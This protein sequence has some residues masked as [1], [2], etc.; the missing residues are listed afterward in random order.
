M[1]E[2]QW[3][4]ELYCVSPV[5]IPVWVCCRIEVSILGVSSS[6]VHGGG[7][8]FWPE[9]VSFRWVDCVCVCVVR[10]ESRVGVRRKEDC[11]RVD[12]V[13]RSGPAERLCST[14]VVEVGRSL[15]FSVSSI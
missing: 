7:M 12:L 8:Q 4:S 5:W 1:S 14:G 9:F 6:W 15:Q 11:K 13:S 3:R 2:S 10:G